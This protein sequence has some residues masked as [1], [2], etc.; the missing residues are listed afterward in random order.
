[1]AFD[2][3]AF[4]GRRHLILRFLR[5]G[6]VRWRREC[7]HRIKEIGSSLRIIPKECWMRMAMK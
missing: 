4:D 1:M 2:V 3:D 6:V 7:R 5:F